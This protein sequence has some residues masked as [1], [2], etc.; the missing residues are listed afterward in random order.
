MINLKL[1]NCHEQASY[2]DLK[3]RVVR[4][5]L[6]PNIEAVDIIVWQTGTARLL[7]RL[8]R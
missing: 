4:D 3:T 1:S 6:R 5:W 7:P 2:F 8:R